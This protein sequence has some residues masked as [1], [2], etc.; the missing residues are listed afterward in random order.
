[1]RQY[2]KSQERLT[3]TLLLQTRLSLR[4]MFLALFGSAVFLPVRV[5]AQELVSTERIEDWFYSRLVWAGVLA[6][7]LGGLVGALHLSRLKAHTS[8]LH[9]NTQARRKFWVWT[10]G[11][12][13][14]GAVLLLIDVWTFYSFGGTSLSFTSALTEVWFN[15]RTIL[16]LLVAFIS[17]YLLIALTTR[18]IRSSRCPYAFLP[19]PRGK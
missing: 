16:I 3:G 19:G 11:V 17:F 8:E 5:F 2:G 4:I 13:M 14:A 7:I 10:I 15:Y 12:L 1:M 9:V 18:F 6:A